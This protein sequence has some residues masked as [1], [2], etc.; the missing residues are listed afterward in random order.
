[1]K[2]K[3]EFELIALRGS[4]GCYEASMYH[5]KYDYFKRVKFYDYSIKEIYYK[6]RHEY[7]C[8]VVRGF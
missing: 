1:M 5:L 2:N 4:R 8:M 6:L 3:R 7:N